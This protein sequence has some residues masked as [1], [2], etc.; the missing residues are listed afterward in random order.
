MPIIGGG[1]ADGG[2]LGL[3]RQREQLAPEAGVFGT[4]YLAGVPVGQSEAPVVGEA[5]LGD[6]DGGELLAEHRLHGVTQE[7]FHRSECV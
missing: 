2:V 5:S 3:C 1:D 7:P 4:R 6:V